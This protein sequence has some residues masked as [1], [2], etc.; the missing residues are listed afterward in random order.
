MSLLPI[1]NER[2]IL[3]KLILLF[4]LFFF[5]LSFFVVTSSWRGKKS[6]WTPRNKRGSSSSFSSSSNFPFPRLRG[7]KG[8]KVWKDE[9]NLPPPPR[10]MALDESSA[11][12]HWPRIRKKVKLHPTK[13]KKRLLLLLRENLFYLEHD[14]L[15]PL[16]SFLAPRKK[17][18]LFP[19]RK[20]EEKDFFVVG[21]PFDTRAENQIL[22]W[23]PKGRGGRR[24]DST[25]LSP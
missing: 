25:L 7:E 15:P 9:T 1:S 6:W 22:S 18:V 4:L 24:R 23:P 8:R 11:T 19:R 16:L 10:I 3:I 5:F 14:F 2:K 12:S 21:P 20:E 17:A 13:P